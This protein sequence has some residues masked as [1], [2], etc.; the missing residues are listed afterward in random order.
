[1]NKLVLNEIH[2][3]FKYL[4]DFS[5]EKQLGKTQSS[6]NITSNSQISIE[7]QTKKIYFPFHEKE[8]KETISANCLKITTT[9]CPSSPATEN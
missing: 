9:L 4:F 5:F 7:P 8:A 1:M 2:D 3:N 6:K